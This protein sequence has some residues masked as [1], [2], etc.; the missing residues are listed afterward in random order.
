MKRIVFVLVLCFAAVLIYARP[1]F[2][3]CQMPCGI[4]NDDMRFDMIKEDISTIE[5]AIKEIDELSKAGEKNYNQIVLWVNTKEDHANKIME[6][7][8]GYFLAQRVTLPKDDMDKTY[9][10]KLTLLHQIIVY[11]MKTKQSLDIGNVE[12]LKALTAE[13]EKIY[14]QK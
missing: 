4:Y 2:S 6:T 14:N 11:A 7:A 8:S 5:K 13:F 10:N 12:K 3:H 9:Q 1:G